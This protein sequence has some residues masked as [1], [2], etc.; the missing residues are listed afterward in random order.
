MKIV[1]DG[2]KS[3]LK[4]TPLIRP[5]KAATVMNL[6]ATVEGPV[7][8]ELRTLR[9]FSAACLRIPPKVSN[10]TQIVMQA[11]FDCFERAGAV[12]EGLIGDL[13]WG[14]QQCGIAPDLTIRGLQDMSKY[15]Y[16]KFQAKD[17]SFVDFSSDAITGAFVRYQ[18]PLLDMVY[19]ETYVRSVDEHPSPK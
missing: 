7:K 3:E 12:E 2:E 17:N 4:K 14:F 19:E 5:D 13:L 10:E 6:E 11:L 18:P 16:V 9:P 15:G 1:S 8:Q